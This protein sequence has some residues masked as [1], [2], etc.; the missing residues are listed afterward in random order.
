MKEQPRRRQTRVPPSAMSAMS[1]GRRH[2]QRHRPAPRGT[3]RRFPVRL[4]AALAVAALVVTGIIFTIG[5]RDAAPTPSATV[6]ED[7]STVIAYGTYLGGPQRRSY[8]LGPAPDTLEVIWKSEIGTGQTSR[9]SDG[10]LVLWSGM[11]WTGQPLVVLDD[12]VPNL[13]VG[14]YDHGLRRLD[15]ATGKTVWRYEFDDV[16]KGTP[17]VYLDTSRAK[18]DRAVI[19][20]GSRRGTAFEIGDPEIAP[21]RAVAFSSGTEIWRMGVPKT[22][23]YSQDVDASSLSIDGRIISAVEPGFVYAL[24]AHRTQTVSG[25][26]GPV[27]LRTSPPLYTTED[28]RDHPDNGGANIAIEGSPAVLDDRIYIATGSGHVYGLDRETLAIEWDYAVGGDFDSTVAVTRD[29]MLL[30]GMER[31]YVTGHGGVFML[32]PRKPPAEALVWFFPTLDRGISEWG[33]GVVGS[34]AVNDESDPDGT[35]PP[36][37]A[38]CSVDGNLYVVASNAIAEKRVSGPNGEP[39]LPAPRLIFK[40]HIGGSIST[41]IIIGDRIVAVG[42]DSTVHLYQIAYTGSQSDGGVIGRDGRKVDVTIGEIGSIVLGGQI[43]STPLVWD[44]RVYIGC[45]DGFLYCLGAR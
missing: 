45:R 9:K 13:I 6:A 15:M 23:H 1:G 31:E 7:T 20:A 10:K 18:G 8:G 24:D 28:V 26:I 34:V 43:E 22:E 29:G 2:V 16:I 30:V 33:G 36:L 42:F 39:G 5:S 32:D 38:F 41:P 35:R 25:V 12:G 3:G 14:G 21:L 44:G 37:A 4:L 19:V 11:G 40:D 27:M 17:A